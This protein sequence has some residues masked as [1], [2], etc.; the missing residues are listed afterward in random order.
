MR[1]SAFPLAD[2]SIG[3]RT[4]P[5]L[6][7]PGGDDY[8]RLAAVNDGWALDESNVIELK[9]DLSLDGGATWRF[10]A[11]F[12]A[13]GEQPTLRPGQEAAPSIGV[14][15][16]EPNNP[17]RLIRIRLETKKALVTRV[18]VESA[19]R[20]LKVSVAEEPRSVAFDAVGS[21]DYAFVSSASWTHTPGG[22]PSG[23]G[24]AITNLAVLPDTTT[25]STV[26]YGGTNCSEEVTV[27]HASG[28]FVLRGSIWGLASPTSGAQTVVV[29]FANGGNY[30]ACGSITVTGGDA[31]TLFSNTASATTLGTDLTVDITSA[32]DELVMDSAGTARAD[33]SLTVGAG[34]TERFNLENAG[35]D[36]RGGASTEP[37][38]AMVTMSWTTRDTSLNA[39]AAGS[40]KAAGVVAATRV[41][42]Q[43]G[44][45]IVNP[46]TLLRR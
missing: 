41:R 15:L 6:P 26:T 42:R 18:D 30:G 10:L 38:A 25:V 32:A 23:V 19:F 13:T 5:D 29:T 17:D 4:S 37:G 1:L 31:A 9:A 2:Y 11:G 40:V 45:V 36:T 12:T 39:I 27:T 28:G 20:N 35:S 7:L 14:Q 44:G 43:R 8:F 24:V 22:T 21:A 34:Q 33:P 46:G 16:P 3:V